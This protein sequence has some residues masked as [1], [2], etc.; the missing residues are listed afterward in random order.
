MRKFLKEQWKDFIKNEHEKK[1]GKAVFLEKSWNQKIKIKIKKIERK[2]KQ[3]D[4]SMKLKEL[5]GR[6]F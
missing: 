4:G 5:Q 2:G 1:I 3:N 6:K